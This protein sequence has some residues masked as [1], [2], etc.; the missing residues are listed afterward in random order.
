MV[1]QQRQNPI[2]EPNPTNVFVERIENLLNDF[3]HDLFREAPLPWVRDTV[4]RRIEEKASRFSAGMNPTLH[5]T[6]H[7]SMVRLDIPR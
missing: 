4:L 6:L 2:L 7:R 5:F 3:F 1:F